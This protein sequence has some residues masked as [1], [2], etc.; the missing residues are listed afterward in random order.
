[1]RS[2]VI[3][4]VLSRITPYRKSTVHIKPHL[5]APSEMGY[6]YYGK[7]KGMGMGMGM[8]IGYGYLSR[9]WRK[10]KCKCGEKVGWI[11]I[12]RPIPCDLLR[13][14]DCGLRLNMLGLSRCFVCFVCCSINK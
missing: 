3:A 13:I 2:N 1:M 12:T 8:D 14:A 9:A 5:P 10:C 11:R 6:A 4:F 7:G